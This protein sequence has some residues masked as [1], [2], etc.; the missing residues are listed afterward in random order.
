MA[1]PDGFYWTRDNYG[2]HWLHAPQ[3]VV[4][5]VGAHVGG[6]WVIGAYRYRFRFPKAPA[7]SLPTAQRWLERWACVNAEQ[8][9]QAE[10]EPWPTSKPAR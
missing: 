4:G 5:W 8:L 2:N 1:L 6:G 7:P 10:R 9:L 3:A